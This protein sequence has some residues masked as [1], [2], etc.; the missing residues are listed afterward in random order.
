MTPNVQLTGLLVD[1]L[2]DHLATG[3]APS[4]PDAGKLIWQAFVALSRSRSYSSA[5]PNPINFQEIE[6]WCRLMR[7]PLGPHHV[8]MICAL[9][10]AW[11]RADE[12]PRVKGN[13]TASV[14]DAVLSC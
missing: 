12:K 1:A 11:L 14:F 6:A 9:D 5:G 10:Q 13:L 8:E 4:I 3:A 2:R 7:I